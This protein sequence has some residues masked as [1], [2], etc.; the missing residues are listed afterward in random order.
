[1]GA[2][3]GARWFHVSHKFHCCRCNCQASGVWADCNQCR[4]DSSRY[5]TTRHDSKPVDS[6]SAIYSRVSDSLQTGAVC[7]RPSLP[8]CLSV[9][10]SVHLSVCPSVCLSIC[11]SVC[12]SACLP[13]CLSSGIWSVSYLTLSTFIALLVGHW[14]FWFVE[15]I[16]LVASAQLYLHLP[17]S[18]V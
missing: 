4:H 9:R 11:L 12:L 2:Y 5:P 7:L 14:M 15:S 6:E 16:S 13:A 1:M 18:C 10:P 17:V 8:G 3:M